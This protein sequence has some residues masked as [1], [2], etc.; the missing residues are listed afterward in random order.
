[1]T[2]TEK[3]LPPDKVFDDIRN[4][5]ESIIQ[6]IEKELQSYQ[7]EQIKF[8]E[9]VK[10]LQLDNCHNRS[11]DVSKDSEINDRCVFDRKHVQLAD[12]AIS[13]LTKQVQHLKEERK[14]IQQL[15]KS[16]QSTIAN[17]ESEINNYR[18]QLFKPSAFADVKQQY[19]NTIKNLEKVIANQKTEIAKQAMT[20]SSL[21]DDKTQSGARIKEL[22][23]KI[24]EHEQVVL[25]QQQIE[26]TNA[27]LKQKLEEVLKTNSEL[28][29]SATLVKG[30]MDERFVREKNALEKLQEALL[31]A[32]TA[33][34]EKE[35]A[36]KRELIIKEECDTLATTIGQVME[37]AACKVEKN[38]EE[39]RAKYDE[40]E[41]CLLQKHK[42]LKMELENQIKI[43][44][45]AEA[46][47]LDT[48]RKLDFVL[49]ENHALSAELDVASQTII[50]ME[51]KL[52]ATE[53][54]LN[55]DRRTETLCEE[56]EQQLRYYMENNHQIKERWKHTIEDVTK[57][58]SN[59]IKR[60]Q[61][62]NS[63]LKAEIDAQIFKVDPSNV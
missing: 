17:L 41:M 25:K 42:K 62:E 32:E 11:K 37:E 9:Q 59:E 52:K 30:M 16:S 45:A 43:N 13:N 44:Q 38:I 47:W 56:R 33:V 22:Q 46:R 58:F 3:S 1:M 12:D 39:L 2:D 34:A 36:L 4:N 53:R 31:I 21:R 40:K 26:Q 49:K 23:R 35:E 51:L 61:K 57:K 8:K 28:E 55:E 10:N 48:T 24:Q 20:I 6:K 19:V 15:W 7:E 50:N 27:S 5:Y 63:S 29:V 14:T 60:L 18:H 54:L